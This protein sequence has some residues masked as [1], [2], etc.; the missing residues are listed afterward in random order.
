M[1]SPFA[2][3][4]RLL[5]ERGYSIVPIRP[6]KK[7]PGLRKVGYWDNLDRWS[8]YCYRQC[9]EDELETWETWHEAGIG[10]CTGPASGVVALDFDKV[11]SLWPKLEA[12]IPRSP[13]VKRGMNGYTAFYRYAEA[14]HDSKN[15]T[16]RE[17]T[18]DPDGK[19]NVVELLS[20]GRQTVIPP[21]IHPD[22]R[23]AYEWDGTALWDMSPDELPDLPENLIELFDEALGV[24]RPKREPRIYEADGE[25]ESP[26]FIAA[27]LASFG[28]ELDAENWSA[29]G[30]SI[31]SVYPDDTGFRLWDEWSARDNREGQYRPKTMRRRW[32]RLDPEG[33]GV[34]IGTVRHF[35]E[36]G[37]FTDWHFD[38]DRR[39]ADVSA[40]LIPAQKKSADVEPP[41]ANNELKILYPSK[42]VH[43]APG[44]V[45]EIAAWITAS[46]VKPQPVLSLGAALAFVGAVKAKRQ[47]TRTNLR[48][49]IYVLGLGETGSGKNHPIDAVQHLHACVYGESQGVIGDRPVSEG[50]LYAAVGDMKGRCLIVWDEI[51]HA[52]GGMSNKNAAVHQSAIMT[53]F[54]ELFSAAGRVFP[55]RRLAAGGREALIKPCLSVYGTTVAGRFFEA[56]NDGQ[57]ID[58]FLAR[59]LVFEVETSWPDENEDAELNDPSRSIVE[60]LRAINGEFAVHDETDHAVKVPYD[61]AGERY[62]RQMRAE[63]REKGKRAEKANDKA[64]PIWIRA[65]E[66]VAK[67]ALIVTDG[68]ETT[69]KE[70][71]WAHELVNIQCEN[72]LHLIE[73]RM[74]ENER[75]RLTKRVLRCIREAGARGLSKSDITNATLH[76]AKRDRD[77]ILSALEES[78]RIEAFG[79]SESNGDGAKRKGRPTKFYRCGTR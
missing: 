29:V 70:L 23:R 14:L 79:S 20:A 26:E 5:F 38:E 72:M 13:V 65:A 25:R 57:V 28:P 30:S 31:K 45:G 41:P 10:I 36:L 1:S 51:G 48:T 15:W 69:E 68:D 17:V 61:P 43:G 7:I 22:T 24:A 75:E 47:R 52:I 44:I 49:N 59:W 53:G 77:E 42:L 6:R 55:G 16:I 37:G 56:L 2:S 21:S 27:M 54:T 60:R 32:D 3:V 74:S 63:F 58:G 73:T 76:M 46:A 71:R 40:E 12:L 18:G 66:H 64:A 8:E 4:A 62:Y 39:L 34:T 67:V 50:G 19:G 9:T 33:K 78:G 35:A 11:D